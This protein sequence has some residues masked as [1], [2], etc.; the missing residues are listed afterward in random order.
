ML[1]C[2]FAS[3]LASGHDSKII[4]NLP[5]VGLGQYLGELEFADDHSF[6]CAIFFQ[7][8]IELMNM[9]IYKN[10]IILRI[11]LRE[12]CDSSQLQL[13]TL[14]CMSN[15]IV[16]EGGDLFRLLKFK[17]YPSPMQCVVNAWDS[18]SYI[19]NGGSMDPT[20]D[21]KLISG[22]GDGSNLINTSYLHNPFFTTNLIK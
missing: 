19:G 16:H 8:L 15:V 7:T 1:E 9:Q 22:A 13:D 6:A 4:I 10:K 21:G 20:I 2:I 12:D 11:L 14:S 3:A 17:D 18:F 5:L